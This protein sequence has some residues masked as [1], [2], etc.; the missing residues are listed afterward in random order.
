[1]AHRGAG[2]RNGAPAA[3]GVCLVFALH[4]CRRF[5][6]VDACPARGRRSERRRIR[7][8]QSGRRRPGPRVANRS[9]RRRRI[10][11]GDILRPAQKCSRFP[12]SKRR[13]KAQRSGARNHSTDF[14][15]QGKL[16]HPRYDV[17]FQ[18]SDLSRTRSRGFG[19]HSI[20]NIGGQTKFGP[21]VEWVESPDYEVDPSRAEGFY[22]AIRG[23]WRSL[24]TAICTLVM[25][26]FDPCSPDGKAANGERTSSYKEGK[27]MAWPGWSIST[28]WN[29]PASPHR[30]P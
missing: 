21:D 5:L 15:C 11:N 29:L 26:A 28:A 14:P 1:M 25:P 23:Y 3:G 18:V 22:S 4:G 10:T 7:L 2:P 8:F 9:R 27:A 20:L 12:C 30:L 19:T 24:P 17:A 16:F 6:W 13:T